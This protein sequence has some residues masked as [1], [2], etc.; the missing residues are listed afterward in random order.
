MSDIEFWSPTKSNNVKRR[1]ETKVSVAEL[2]GIF[3]EVRQDECKMCARLKSVRCGEC[4]RKLKYGGDVTA[5]KNSAER[6]SLPIKKVITIPNNSKISN[7]E[8][9]NTYFVG[10][11]GSGKKKH[12]N[13]NLTPVKRKLLDNKQV[14]KL[15]HVFDNTRVLPAVSPGESVTEESPAKKRKLEHGG[16]GSLHSK[17]RVI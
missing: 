10:K 3:G 5:R 15:V 1:E 7:Y 12:M 17:P 9:R 11:E 8:L 6:S 2:C 13:S 14:S 4:V 16:G